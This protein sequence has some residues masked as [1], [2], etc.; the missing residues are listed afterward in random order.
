MVF[1]E[2]FFFCTTGP[3][4]CMFDFEP[5][6]PIHSSVQIMCRIHEKKKKLFVKK[7][8]NKKMVTNTVTGTVNL[9]VL[10]TSSTLT[11]PNYT[12]SGLLK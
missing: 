2:D 11:I 9:S 6:L 7:Q 10:G 12:G 3:L 1:K 8:T 5:F 4:V